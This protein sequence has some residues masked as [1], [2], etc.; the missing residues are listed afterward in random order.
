M[1]RH[2]DSIDKWVDNAW[3]LILYI[4][5]PILAVV[6]PVLLILGMIGVIR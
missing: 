2:D 6:Y 4:I 1:T 5:V 3:T